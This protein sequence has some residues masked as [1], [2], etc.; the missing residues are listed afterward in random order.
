MHKAMAAPCA[1]LRHAPGLRVR[2]LGRPS[3]LLSHPEGTQILVAGAA[4]VQDE[5]VVHFREKPIETW[6]LG[7]LEQ[8]RR[9]RAR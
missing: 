3:R 2:C 7:N 9:C 6:N 5:K 8:C 1:R 4:T